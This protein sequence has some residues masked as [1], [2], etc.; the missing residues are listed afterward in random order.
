MLVAAPWRR[1]VCSW[2]MFIN[3]NFRP[4]RK[5]AT[6]QIVCS[7]HWNA[8]HVDKWYYSKLMRGYG[9]THAHAPRPNMRESQPVVHEKHSQK[10]CVS[11]INARSSDRIDFLLG[12]KRKNLA[13]ARKMWQRPP[14]GWKYL[15]SLGHPW[16]IFTPFLSREKWEPKM[17]AAW[18]WRETLSLLFSKAILE[19]LLVN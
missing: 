11:L 17:R 16:S 12:A 6:Q 8:E 1:R 19:D 14:L 13:R 3:F 7:A 4:P 18:C 15:H 5:N 9:M 2:I 10:K